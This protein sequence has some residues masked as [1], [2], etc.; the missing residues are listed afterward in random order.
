MPYNQ[1]A[2]NVIL[3]FLQVPHKAMLQYTNR[4]I[5]P[6]QRA[7]LIAAD[8]VMWG[9]PTG[10]ITSWLGQYLPEDEDVRELVDKGVEQVLLNKLIELGTGQQSRIDFSSLAPS[11]MTGLWSTIAELQTSDLG[12]IIAES[13][14]GQLL[15]GNNPRLTNAFKKAMRF[16]NLIDDYDDPTT[17]GEVAHSFA[18]LSSGYSNALS[19]TGS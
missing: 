14:S 10:L 3:Q 19:T 11:D 15:F 17:F 9:V 4:A 1:N 16:T 13:P 5:S 12:T 8:T 18:Q 2:A 6:K 7:A